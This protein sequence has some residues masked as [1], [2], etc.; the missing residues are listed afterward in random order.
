M[1]SSLHRWVIPAVAAVTIGGVWATVSQAAPPTRVIVRPVVPAPVISPRFGPTIVVAPT[2]PV[3]RYTYNPNVP[4]RGYSNVLAANADIR[5]TAELNAYLA[6]LYAV[7]YVNPYYYSAYT[8]FIYSPFM[9][10]PY[11]FGLYP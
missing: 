10:D 8:P 6:S 1:F 2:L 3:P 4:G 5:Y 7:P 11:S 9:Y